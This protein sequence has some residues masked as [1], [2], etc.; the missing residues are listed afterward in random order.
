MATIWAGI[1]VETVVSLTS[2]VEEKL[3]SDV[4]HCSETVVEAALPE[5]GVQQDTLFK[6]IA[7]EIDAHVEFATE[8]TAP[9][10]LIKFATP[11]VVGVAA[12]D[13]K[14]YVAV[15]MGLDGNGGG[16]KR[17]RPGRARDRNLR[18]FWRLGIRWMILTSVLLDRPDMKDLGSPATNRVEP[19]TQGYTRKP[20]TGGHLRAYEGP[21]GR[22]LGRLTP[23]LSG[24]FNG[25][26]REQNDE[27]SDLGE[28]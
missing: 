21:W 13:V 12:D 11:M 23:R 20:S 17:R 22:R 14:R 1:A 7:R 5:T 15:K 25:K 27:C 18:G 10:I 16:C 9:A 3:V 2:E 19:L 24:Q 28:V 6:R 4:D 26:R 8:H